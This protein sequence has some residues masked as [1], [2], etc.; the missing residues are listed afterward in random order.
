MEGGRR[1]G[2]DRE[3]RGQPA[4]LA[5]DRS[6]PEMN[7]TV[8]LFFLGLLFVV[9]ER[10]HP[11][12]KRGLW[13]KQLG[14]D[15]FY[16]VFHGEYLGL[17]LAKAAVGL[18]A[19]ASGG[20]ITL[21][22]PLPWLANSSWPSASSL[23]A[24]A[25]LPI[26]ILVFDFLQYG[27]HNLLHRVPVLWRFHQLHHSLEEMDWVGN[28]RFHW[29]EV[30]VYRVLLYVPAALLGFSDSVLFAYGIWN[31][32]FG[33]FAHA[34]LPYSAGPLRYLVNT[35][36]MHRWHHVHP[37]A[38]PLQKNFGITLSIWDWLFGTAYLPKGKGPERLGLQEQEKFPTNILGQWLWPFGWRGERLD[39][40]SK[41]NGIEPR[42]LADVADLHQVRP[43][44][45]AA[46]G[47]KSQAGD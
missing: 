40:E 35:P 36:A 34:N 1:K 41:R 12:Q 47:P 25:Q 15:L 13:R 8:W 14:N 18:Q 7:Y 29:G 32:F 44:R 45:Q 43:A 42:A 11:W 17:V 24:I 28:W 26:L 6:I 27:I 20:P 37:S 19:L 16:L 39:R 30:I 22:Q 10:L 46:N 9:A 38:G 33:H 21:W 3:E 5:G 31:T 4:G 2:D 23:P